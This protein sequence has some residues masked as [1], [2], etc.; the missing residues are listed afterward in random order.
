MNGVNSAVNQAIRLIE[1]GVFDYD[2]I[3]KLL[4]ERGKRTL[5]GIDKFT[6]DSE[7]YDPHSG[8][9]VW[10]FAKQNKLIEY[11]GEDENGDVLVNITGRGILFAARLKEK[12]LKLKKA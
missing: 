6:W 8:V 9:Y 5:I 11:A 1:Y 3:D 7:E 10:I 4:G 2:S 12:I